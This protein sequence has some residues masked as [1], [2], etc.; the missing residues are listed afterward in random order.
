M[1]VEPTPK[2]Q[3]GKFLSASLVLSSIILRIGLVEMKVWRHILS[4]YVIYMKFK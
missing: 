3:S 2:I 4:Y 1:E